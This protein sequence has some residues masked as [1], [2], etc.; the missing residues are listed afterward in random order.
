MIVKFVKFN[1]K[2]NRHYESIY[3]AD[4]I[5]KKILDH[6]AGCGCEACESFKGTEKYTDGFRITTISCY[7]ASAYKEMPDGETWADLKI[8]GVEVL[9]KY[10]VCYIMNNE[11]R[12]VETIRG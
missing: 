6:S 1:E 11:G 7:G 4:K 10:D 3:E 12:T 2:E 8:K 5:E 9:G